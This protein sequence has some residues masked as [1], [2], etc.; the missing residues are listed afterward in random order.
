MP[1]SV[2]EVLGGPVWWAIL[3]LYLIVIGQAIFVRADSLR[4]KRRDRFAAIP[5]PRL[6][7]TGVATIYLI[8]VVTAW[9]PLFPRQWA[10]V[11]VLM[12]PLAFVISTA[13][14]L[15]V[16]FPKPAVAL[17]EVDDVEGD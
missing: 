4:T 7:Y 9:T 15:R 10:L 16:V 17:A 13:Y 1:F 8:C 2:T 6:L 14:L 11:P 12:T 5:E 3:T